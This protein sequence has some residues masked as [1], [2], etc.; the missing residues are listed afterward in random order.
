MTRL[1]P[2]MIKLSKERP[3]SNHFA[4]C[5]GILATE[6]ATILQCTEDGIGSW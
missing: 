1:S 3:I 6:D 5:Y 2:A 4:R